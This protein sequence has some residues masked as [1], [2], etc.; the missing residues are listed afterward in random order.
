MTKL[1]SISVVT[2]DGSFAT[3]PEATIEAGLFTGMVA[4]ARWAQ[5]LLGTNIAWTEVTD[6]FVKGELVSTGERILVQFDDLPLA[7]R[8][9]LD[10]WVDGIDLAPTR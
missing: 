2:K 5:K 10:D 1:Y 9:L 6:R 3:K 7:A 8:D 4:A